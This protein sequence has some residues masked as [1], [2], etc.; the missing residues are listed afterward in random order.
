MGRYYY[1][2]QSNQNLT[3]QIMKVIM[4]AKKYIKLSS[5]LMQDK[6]VVD[7]LKKV[8]TSGQAAVFVISNQINRE[9]EE[10]RF[11]DTGGKNKGSENGK[12][13]INLHQY[14]L[15]GLF[16]NG[17]HVRLLKEL[18]AK[19]IIADGEQGLL[20]SANISPNSLTKN[21][22]SGISLTGEQ[23]H[24]LERV[25]DIMYTHADIVQFIGEGNR[26]IVK[27][28]N[29]K[30]IADDLKCLTG[31]IKMTA[32]QHYSASAQY[33]DSNFSEINVTTL[34]ETIIDIINEARESVY[35][36]S[37]VFKDPHR[38]LKKF[39][40]AVLNAIERGVNIYLFY[41]HNMPEHNERNQDKYI[42][43]LRE[44]GCYVFSDNINH[45]KCI[46]NESRGFLFTA[47]IDGGTGLL[48]GFE[49]GAIMDEE[50]YTEALAH[51]NSL[52]NTST[53]YN[54]NGR[55]RY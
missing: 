50:Q 43:Y 37:W 3:D 32:A 44:N 31:D 9:D 52:I 30:I 25:F 48:E 11:T 33:D 36:V 1:N 51:V 23:L 4:S 22:E 42:T 2:D 20:M 21:V 10:Y 13:G 14:F 46:L 7:A 12:P 19:F 16:Y 24:D 41:N 26:D 49:V 17:I 45:S 29:R 40:K 53:K 5:F 8:S 54:K 18:H 35:I 55:T 6:R 39:Q 28:V 47:N 27:K 15:Q 34:Y 38:K